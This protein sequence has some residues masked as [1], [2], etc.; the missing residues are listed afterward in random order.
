MNDN[1]SS[2][3]FSEHMQGHFEK[4]SEVLF[5]ELKSGE[6]LVLNLDAEESLYIRF[7]GNRVRQNTDVDQ[8]YLSLKYC[9]SG[10]TVD[11]QQTLTRNLEAD[12]ESFLRALNKCRCEA[13]ILPPDPNQ[14][15]IANNGTSH[16]AFQGALPDRQNVIELITRPSEGMDLAGLYCGGE[17]ISANR[18]SKGQNHWFSNETFFMDYSV[19]DGNRAVK[20]IYAGLQWDSSEW[21]TNLSRPRTQLA[22]LGRPICKVN[23]GQYRTYLAPGAV[24]ELM[25]MF[26]WGA[27]SAAAWK[28]GHSPFKKL[29]EGEVQLSP[30]FNLQENF[31]LGLSPRFN[32]L[33]E[34]APEILSLIEDGKI[35]ELLVSSRTAKEYGLKANA[36]P[37]SESMRAPEILPGTLEEKNILR[38]LGS[39]LYVSNLHYL[40]WSDRVS[41]RITGMTR[42]ACFWVEGG[43]IVGPIQDLRFD[44][45]LYDALGSKLMAL[46][47]LSEIDPSVSTYGAR[48]LGGRVAPGMLIDGFTFTL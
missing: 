23:P 22:M 8:A 41:A 13:K 1:F 11:Y 6:D 27:V 7:N 32:G 30:F 46:T 20:S 4:I 36:A 44:E 15:V 42:Y 38:E 12:R 34:V 39:G 16:A 28:Q 29:I 24:S 33:G 37:E 3:N 21:E 45:S 19:Y 9:F 40:N 10:R 35:K 48:A 2:Q 25:S 31:R 14:V 26:S 43:E 47:S 5:S 18:N 17:V